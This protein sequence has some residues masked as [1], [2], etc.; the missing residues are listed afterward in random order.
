MNSKVHPIGCRSPENE[1][2]SIFDLFLA[3]VFTKESIIALVWPIFLYKQFLIKTQY[4]ICAV[5][6]S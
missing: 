6:I 1:S 2:I 4:K 3:Y 5:S